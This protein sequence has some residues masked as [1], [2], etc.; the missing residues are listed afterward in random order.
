LKLREGVQ[1][2]G[3]SVMDFI[4]DMQIQIQKYNPTTTEIDAISLIS[5]SLRPYYLER[6]SIRN[7]L[8][9]ENMLEELTRIETGY[10][11]RRQKTLFCF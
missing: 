7:F 6:I 1:K 8:T 5:G 2:P 11:V 4:Y 9:V 10:N 3:E